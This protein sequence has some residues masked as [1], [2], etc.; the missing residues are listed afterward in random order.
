MD[1]A[2]ARELLAAEQGRLEEIRADLSEEEGELDDADAQD[3]SEAVDGQHPGD[4][5]TDLF[6]RERDLG[7]LEDVERQLHEVEEALRRLDEGTY[8]VCDVCGRPIPDE[9]LEANPTARYDVEHEPKGAAG[10][11]APL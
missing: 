10:L 11:G 7:E 6:E 9:R 4:I 1:D 3:S 8:G 5:G 2:H